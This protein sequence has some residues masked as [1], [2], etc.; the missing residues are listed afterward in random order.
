MPGGLLLVVVAV[1]VEV[2]L[3]GMGRGLHSSTSQLNLSALYGIGGT[4]RGCAGAVYGVLRGRRGCA[5]CVFVSLPVQ[6]ELESGRV[7][8]APACGAWAHVNVKQGGVVALRWRRR[9]GSS[10]TVRAAVEPVTTTL[11]Q[12]VQQGAP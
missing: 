2:V 7:Y 1:V 11:T 6:V 3:G 10:S 8:K 5:G 4:S 9:R 12:A